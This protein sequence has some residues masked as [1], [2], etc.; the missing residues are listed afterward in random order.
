M[1]ENPLILALPKGRVLEKVLPLLVNSRFALKDSPDKTRKII[2][3]TVS[4]DLKVIIVRGWDIPTYVASGSAHVGIVGKDILLEKNSKEYF[5]ITDLNIAH[6]RLSLAGPE[7][8]DKNITKLKVA[9]KYPK[10]SKEYLAAK[11]IQAETIY[12]NGAIEIAPSLGLSDV[13]IDLVDTGKT[14]EENGLKEL[15]IIK[16]ITSRLIV[17][18][19]S[20]KTKGTII[21]LLMNNL[22]GK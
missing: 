13:I 7:T 8:L 14:L 19:A 17:N 16:P 10:F 15:D 22:L 6:C 5:E 20:L 2:L 3:D 18:K 21:D 1:S 12:L 9:T 11:G 4:N